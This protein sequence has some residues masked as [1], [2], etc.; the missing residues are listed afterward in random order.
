M[1]VGRPILWGLAHSGED[2]V[3][4]VVQLLKAEFEL[5]MGLSG[6]ISFLSLYNFTSNCFKQS[7]CVILTFRMRINW[8]YRFI[9]NLQHKVLF[10]I[11]IVIH[12][13]HNTKEAQ[14]AGWRY[15]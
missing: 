10:V 15:S 8:G 13:N 1:F 9:F 7:N 6:H 12:A 3:R 11:V 5:A 4:S 2:G 14:P